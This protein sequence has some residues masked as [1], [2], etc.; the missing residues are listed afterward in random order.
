MA[1]PVT[2]GIA[3]T[4]AAAALAKMTNGQRK[5]VCVICNNTDYDLHFQD[6]NQPSWYV[7]A[8]GGDINSYPTIIKANSVSEA[9]E[10]SAG[11]SAW[12]GFIGLCKEIDV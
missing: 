4:I 8:L 6:F 9:I 12:H 11:K 10:T 5:I 3:T 2:L 1:D 7:P